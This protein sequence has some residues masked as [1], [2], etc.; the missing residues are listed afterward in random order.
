VQIEVIGVYRGVWIP[1]LDDQFN[2]IALGASVEIEQ[3]VLVETQLSENA[4]QA[5]I[6]GHRNQNRF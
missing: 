4:I 3:G 1:E 6:R 2:A 5:W